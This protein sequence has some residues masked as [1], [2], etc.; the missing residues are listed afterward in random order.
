MPQTFLNSLL[1]PLA[2]RR[3]LIGVAVVAL[4][5]LAPAI[6][7][8]DHSNHG[9]NGVGHQGSNDHDD[10]DDSPGQGHGQG[11]GH[12]NSHSH[13]HNHGSGHG[14]DHHHD[15]KKKK[16]LKIKFNRNLAFGR[17]GGDAN[18]AGKVTINPA[19]GAKI[20]TGLAFN[21]GGN[22]SPARLEIKGEKNAYIIVTFPD[23]VRL[24]GRPGGARARLHDFKTQPSGLLQ[25]NHNGQLDLKIGGTLNIAAG[26]PAARYRGRF[27]VEVEYQ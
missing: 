10:D 4:L 21:F 26:Q 24:I 8:A 25:L 14:H 16:K 20:V 15:H 19:T 18:G 12:S 5:A 2:L 22:H 27:R 6:V 1:A 3:L 13:Y 17:V 9:A 23:S 7:G 11:Q